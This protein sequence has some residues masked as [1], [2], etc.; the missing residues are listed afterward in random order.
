MDSHH[1]TVS[2]LL[3]DNRVF[4]VTYTRIGDQIIA[5]S[6]VYEDP[7]MRKRTRL[8]EVRLTN[9]DHLLGDDLGD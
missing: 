8:L 7:T 3:P 6:D 9:G 4:V 5:I 2:E 1:F